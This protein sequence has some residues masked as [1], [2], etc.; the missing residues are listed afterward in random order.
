MFLCMSSVWIFCDVY[1]FLIIKGMNIYTHTY[2]HIC[3]RIFTGENLINTEK[4]KQ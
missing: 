2:I 3:V 4:L 1:F